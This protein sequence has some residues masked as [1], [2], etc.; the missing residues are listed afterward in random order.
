MLT[1]DPE[2]PLAATAA[3]VLERVAL[4]DS[5][6]FDAERTA[7]VIGRDGTFRAGVAFGAPALVP[8]AA[9]WPP[10]QHVGARRRRAAALVRAEQL[11][12]EATELESQ[13]EITASRAAA[14]RREAVQVL[15]AA[16]LFPSRDPLRTAEAGRAA[17]AVEVAELLR[18]L[19]A[20]AEEASRQ[21]REHQRLR[22]EWVERTRSCGL[23]VAL[24]ELAAVETAAR[25]AARTLRT[26]AGELADRYAP[27]LGRLL[28]AAISGDGPT[29]LTELLGKAQA[30]ATRATQ[31]Q[32]KMD[33][34]R[35]SAG[36][37]MGEVLERHRET[38]RELADVIEQ[39][40]TAIKDR[41]GLDRDIVRLTEQLRAAR[42]KA[43]DALPRAGHRIRELARI[44]DVPGVVDAVFAGARPS[45]DHLLIDVATGLASAKSYTKK[46][47]RDRYDEARARLAGSWALGSGDPLGDLDT[48][49]FS[50]GDDSFTPA[51]ATAHAIALADSAEAA[52]AAAEEKALRDFVVGLLPTAIRTSW[53]RMHDWTKE[54][55]RKMRRAA[56]SSQLS[57]QVRINLA[58][59]MSAPART[60]YELACKVF[61]ADRT[62]EQDAAVS[63]ALQALINAAGGETMADKV[64]AAVNIREWVDI[65]YEIHRPDGTTVNWTP[66]TGLSGGER[67]L[68]VLAPMLAAIAAGYDRFGETALRLAA[69]DE[70]PAEVDEQG[71][72]GL[73]RY[74]ATLDLDLI[75]T[76]YLWDGAPGAWDGI[77]AWC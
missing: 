38:A 15:R 73:A 42:E 28:A 9:T 74:L 12:D 5:A 13:A 23:P 54:V 8:G 16:S 48:Y 49:V 51:R 30:A 71:R 35:E 58:S 7:L 14:L 46:T 70:V 67:R 17:K 36:A 29:G 56:A 25:G 41:D 69:L 60:V 39:L 20:A 45:T 1:V 26:S 3:A 59:D 19:D 4:V 61:E 21:R 75:C 10:A 44:L 11:E 22:E 50:Y 72:E 68:V 43:D 33:A 47:L 77:D 32:S 27:R 40:G 55:N 37:V 52:L 2:H 63:Q 31:T 53:V 57:V 76:S 66:R 24:G 6:A 18:E 62:A 65:T 64:A 34:L